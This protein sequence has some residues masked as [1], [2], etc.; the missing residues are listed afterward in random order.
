MDIA[1]LLTLGDVKDSPRVL[2][3]LPGP[4]RMGD[5]VHLQFLLRRKNGT[6]SEELSVTG[7]FRVIQVSFDMR[8]PAARQLLTVESVGVTPMWRAVKNTP[9]FRRRIPPARAPR[10]VIG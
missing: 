4:L 3:V 2:K 7:E 9:A 8:G 1:T 6:R 5:H 10:T